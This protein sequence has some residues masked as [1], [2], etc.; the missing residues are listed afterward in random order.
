MLVICQTMLLQILQA[1]HAAPSLCTLA[2]SCYTRED[3]TIII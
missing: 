3:Q 2:A 1:Q